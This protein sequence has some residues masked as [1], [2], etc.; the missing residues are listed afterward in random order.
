MASGA[1]RQT[2]VAPSGPPTDFANVPPQQTPMIDHSFTLQAVMELQKSVVQLSTKTERLIQDVDKQ[3]DKL[4][5]VL[6]QISFVKG[7]T[8]VL[9]GFIGLIA[10]AVAFYLRTAAR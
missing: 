3:G 4:E 8:W 2:D 1:R 7:A 6:R 10:V 5:V 9:G